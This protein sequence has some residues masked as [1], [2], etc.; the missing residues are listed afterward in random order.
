[1][2][3]II[4]LAQSMGIYSIIMGGYDDEKLKEA[5]KIP[6]RFQ[7]SAVLAL[8]YP[9][10]LEATSPTLRFPLGKDCNG[11]VRNRQDFIW[12]KM[13]CSPVITFLL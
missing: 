11:S 6:K 4:L 7:I 13:E 2:M 1:M 5:F 3:N 8:G 9:L 10:K 12:R